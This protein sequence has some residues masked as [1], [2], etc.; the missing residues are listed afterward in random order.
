MDLSGLKWPLIIAAIV[1][2][3]W[4]GTSG[5]VTWM[6]GN[7]TAATPGVDEAQDLRDE[8]GL[9]KLGGYTYHLWKWQSTIDIIETAI[10]RYGEYAPNY[11]FNMERL[12]TCYERIGEY[13]ISYDILQ[14]LIQANAHEFD[15]R[16]GN[17]DN[18]SLRASKLK[19]MYELP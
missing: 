10:E 1:G 19:E 3:G 13:Q 11:W 6:Y 16:V 8:A 12:S 14:E 7:F 5:G 17:F 15:D 4:M 18:L 9:T 2:I